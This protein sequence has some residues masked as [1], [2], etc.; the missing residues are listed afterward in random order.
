M[1]I[2]W[3]EVSTIDRSDLL[4]APIATCKSDN[5]NYLQPKSGK[6]ND[7]P[8]ILLNHTQGQITHKNTPLNG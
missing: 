2:N 8:N 3:G 1:E 4:L 6:M 7:L 5:W